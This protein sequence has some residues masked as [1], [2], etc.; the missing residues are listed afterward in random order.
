LLE[1]RSRLLE[2]FPRLRLA[3]CAALDRAGGEQRACVLERL[4]VVCMYRVRVSD[5]SACARH[6][7]QLREHQGAASCGSGNP[8][9]EVDASRAPLELFYELLC[10]VRSTE[11]E[12]R[13]D[14]IRIGAEGGGVPERFAVGELD[15]RVEPV[16]CGGE[17][18]E[19]QL[20]QS[21]SPFYPGKCD[22]V[23][24]AGVRC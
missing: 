8:R 4:A 21:Q 11:A 9:G 5:R 10:L 17:V 7:A 20:E 1:D 16:E 13:L 18:A 6:V 22:D 14:G 2:G 23:A 24:G 19:R 12:E 15:E 3:L